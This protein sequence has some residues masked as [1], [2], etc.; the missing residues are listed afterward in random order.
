MEKTSQE[1][2]LPNK[3]CKI[4][5]QNHQ[6][7]K[8]NKLRIKQRTHAQYL[9]IR[10]KVLFHYSNG[11]PKCCNC[12]TDKNLDLHHINNDG[13]EHRKKVKG[14]TH[15]YYWILKHNYPLGFEVR[16]RRCNINAQKP[17]LL[18]LSC[19]LS[20]LLNLEEFC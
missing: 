4:R 3:E 16:C 8:R 13:H 17:K 12:G 1:F 11:E 15:I 14:G 9:K 20:R 10:Y 18:A 6:Y 19:V 7:Y 5:Q 2:S